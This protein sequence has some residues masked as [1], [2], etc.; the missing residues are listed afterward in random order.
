MIRDSVLLKPEDVDTVARAMHEALC[1]SWEAAG[2]E[3][4]QSFLNAARRAL[5]VLAEDGW[6]L[7]SYPKGGW[8]AQTPNN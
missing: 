2:F 1:G 4:K 7:F 8:N 3:V 6:D 5:V